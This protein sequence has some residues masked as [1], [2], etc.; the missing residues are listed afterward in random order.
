MPSSEET[1]A[2][3][4]PGV[5]KIL[6]A[7]AA[8]A[9]GGLLALRMRPAS[10]LFLAGAAAAALIARKKSASSRPLQLL[11]PTPEPEE[12]PA[13]E[14]PVEM[15]AEEPVS[16]FTA[17]PPSAPAPNPIEG[18]LARQLERER[19]SPVITLE[20]L[21]PEI[22]PP[23]AELPPTPELPA[24]PE[25]EPEPE[26]PV[27][28][29]GFI[30]E[31][32]TPVFEKTAPEPPAPKIEPAAPALPSVDFRVLQAL[33]STESSP[34][35]PPTS[36]ASAA[37]L[38]GIEPL[39]SWEESSSPSLFETPQEPLIPMDEAPLTTSVQETPAPPPPPEPAYVPPLFEGGMFPDEIRVD[40]PPEPPSLM[41]TEV[42]AIETS[43]P[44]PTP[45]PLAPEPWF[46]QPTQLVPQPAEPTRIIPAPAQPPAPVVMDA[47]ASLVA[48]IDLFLKAPPPAPAPVTNLDEL[49]PLEAASAPLPAMPEAAETPP[50]AEPQPLD[51]TPPFVSPFLSSAPPLHPI[52][53]GNTTDL[54]P[55]TPRPRGLTQTAVVPRHPF[56][57][58]LSPAPDAPSETPTNAEESPPELPPA[59]VVLPREQKAKRTWRSWWRGD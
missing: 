50:A 2:S 29:S 4:K 14:T 25:P 57:D 27:W 36:G 13:P 9:A 18:W 23:A 32:E 24:V 54:S 42:A 15:P 8:V 52:A 28:S 51:I 22:S 41:H 34:T 17:P 16:S 7:A 26:K 19:N 59:P 3:E 31:P 38:L 46:E 37:W 10:F 5:G 21:T 40:S 12:V 49:M 1:N 45:L 53:P 11:P 48:A 44:E 30:F 56:A 20:V 6:G 58:P 43:A 55:I 33:E 35:A 39:P 47:P